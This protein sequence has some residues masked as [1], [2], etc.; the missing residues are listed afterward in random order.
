MKLL[1]DLALGRLLRRLP[2]RHEI[3]QYPNGEWHCRVFS[4]NPQGV[5]TFWGKS[6]D[7]VMRK[8]ME[9]KL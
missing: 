8:A 2:P 5:R 9:A 3:Y 7:E 1:S 6:P 4:D